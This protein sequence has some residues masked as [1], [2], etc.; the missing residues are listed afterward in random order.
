[1]R[2]LMIRNLWWITAILALILLII[3]SLPGQRIV[4]DSTSV[5]LIL[6]ILISPFL[7]AI[8]KIKF[9]DFE[10][11]IDPKEVERIRNNVDAQ[12]EESKATETGPTP[13]IETTVQQIRS[14]GETDSV[15]AL[16][17][18]RI[19]IEKV[20]LRLHK[21]T[22]SDRFH[23][24]QLSLGKMI[25]NLTTQ[26]IFPQQFSGTIREV[27]SICNRAVHGEEIR[28]KDA[29]AMLDVG[30][31]LLERIFD[32]S[33]DFLLKPDES[34]LISQNEIDDYNK[35]RYRLVTLIPYVEKPVRNVR[36]V[37]QNE[38]N[39]F[40]EGYNEYAEFI[41]ELTRIN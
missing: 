13:E 40:L 9:G 14:L 34:T 19:E 8:R 5:I 24:R 38:L 16:A 32:F 39:D 27:I 1:M 20:V 3:H 15:I 11:E 41:V 6:V 31:S 23:G 18:L 7:S 25:H 29:K 30:T 26:E 4:V 28:E 35:S 22:Q 33:M 2:K 17:K 21:R 10:A 12:L 36:I 37:D